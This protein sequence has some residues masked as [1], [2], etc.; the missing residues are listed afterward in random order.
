MAYLDENED[1]SGNYFSDE[2]NVMDKLYRPCFKWANKYVRDAG[3]FSSHIY[4]VM[5]KE[6][7]DFILRDK[8]NHITLFTNI[9]I[10][11]SDYDAIVNSPE[12]TEE[13]IYNELQNMLD[14]DD[15]VDPV[16]MLAAIVSS[17]QMTVYVSLR[18]RDSES[19]H[20]ITH[21]KSGFFSNDE[22]FVAF[23]GS[24]N[25]TYPA[26]IPGL[27][28]GNKEHFTIY[29]K[30]ELP[31]NTWNRF[32]SPIVERL[33]SDIKGEFPKYSGSGTIIVK[34][35]SIKRESLPAINDDDWD[36]ENHRARAAKRSQRI[37]E[38]MEEKLLETPIPDQEIEETSQPNL[39]KTTISLRPHQQRAITKWKQN[40]FKGIIQHATGSGKTITALTCIE[41]HV[42]TGLPA[43]ILV[44]GRELLDQ[45]IR[46]VER[47]IPDSDI[48]AAGD[49]HDEWR[50]NLTFWTNRRKQKTSKRIVIAIIHTARTELFLQSVG[51][52]DN[53]LV[54]IDEC[55]R[56]GAPSYQGV[57]SW[58]PSKVMGLSA[59]P[60]RYSDE[61]GTE[62]MKEL[63]GE[64]LDEYSIDEAIRDGYL[65]KYFYYIERVGLTN[66]HPKC[67]TADCKQ[68]E[69]NDY[70]LKMEEIKKSLRRYKEKDGGINFS[71]LP[72]G[73][74]VMIFNAKRII[75]SAYQKTQRCAE[76]VEYNYTDDGTQF[77]LVYC[78]DRN[79]LF[80]VKEALR[81]IGKGPVYEYL[82]EAEGAETDSKKLKFD[83]RATLEM[84]E[85]TG[86]IMLAID[87][88]DEGVNIPCISHGII[89]AFS[90][91]PRQFVQRR[92]RLLR[93]SQNKR[94]AHIWDTLVVPESE[95]GGEHTNYVLAEIKRSNIFAKNA[96]NYQALR[97]IQN[98][99]FEL[100]L[101]SESDVDAIEADEV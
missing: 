82:S 75:K 58:N 42:K 88:L 76:I 47:F 51:D 98:I 4:Q 61:I 99:T 81:L 32:G 59:T 100:G 79:Q 30:N 44:P 71:E 5:S 2:T 31:I 7:L 20:S 36:P 27:D 52:L 38:L 96:S 9:D 63:C 57:C 12:K 69:T 11:P 78:E 15:I 95:L 73:L 74:K 65:S 45:W 34:I 3:Y 8:S 46:E 37:Y 89:L 60:T 39:S 62:N 90:Q 23:N 56:I 93:L 55:H 70:D 94:F 24:F 6:V 64:I 28:K 80:D 86:G 87:C 91:N 22:I 29:S 49:N 101:N 17:N 72:E 67:E 66:K 85:S 10:Y 18:K 84:W 40:N 50:K 68:C 92:G 43:L 16:K 77:W 97:E 13:Q 26:V 21:S 35:D 41:E 54:I 25:E 1:I 53:C 14:M 19:P 83:R 48:L 33:K